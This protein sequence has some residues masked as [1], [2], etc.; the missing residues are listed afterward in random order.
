MDGI[1]LVQH[2]VLPF[3][4]EDTPPRAAPFQR[5]AAPSR[6][7]WLLLLPQ[8]RPAPVHLPRQIGMH[9]LCLPD[10][11]VDEQEAKPSTARFV[12]VSKPMTP[13]SWRVSP[14]CPPILPPFVG[15]SFFSLLSSSHTTLLAALCPLFGGNSKSQWWHDAHLLQSHTPGNQRI[16][17]FYHRAAHTA[18]SR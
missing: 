5:R 12:S 15:G 10:I 9:T 4:I 3:R 8:P 14:S 13:L 17:F 7:C 2:P 1:P 6:H 16:C 11:R 18:V